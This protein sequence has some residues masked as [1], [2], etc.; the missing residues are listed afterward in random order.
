MTKQEKALMKKF[1]AQ[2]A[3]TDKAQK[4]FCKA[5]KKANELRSKCSFLKNKININDNKSVDDFLAAW[6]EY[7]AAEE[8]KATAGENFVN[9]LQS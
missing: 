3:A 4:E 9:V 8:I 7:Q 6:G 1:E 5:S 2:Q